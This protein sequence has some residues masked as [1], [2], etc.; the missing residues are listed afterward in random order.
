[1]RQGSS[2]LSLFVCN[3]FPASGVT[4]SCYRQWWVL[5]QGVEGG[6]RAAGL[7]FLGERVGLG[8]VG[9]RPRECGL[10]SMVGFGAG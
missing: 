7:G 1:M 10:Q 6:V 8:L 4:A 5:Q 2:F 9:A 3:I